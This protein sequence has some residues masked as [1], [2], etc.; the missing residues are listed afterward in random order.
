[1][2][3]KKSLMKNFEK[4]HRKTAASEYF[5]NKVAVWGTEDVYQRILKNF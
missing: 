3:N 2:P 5:F 4:T 1:M